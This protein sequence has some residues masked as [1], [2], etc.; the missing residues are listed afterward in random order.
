M[1]N[2]AKAGLGPPQKHQGY[3]PDVVSRYTGLPTRS[4]Y[5]ACAR[6]DIRH[7]RVGRAIIIPGSEVMRLT[8]QDLG[9]SP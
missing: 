8:G 4:I 9:C 1:S 6:G 2:T 5:E 3:R 7:T